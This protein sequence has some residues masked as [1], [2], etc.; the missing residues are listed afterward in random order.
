MTIVQRHVIEVLRWASKKSGMDLLYG[1]GKR[2]LDVGCAFGYTSTALKNLG[3]TTYG[4]DISRWGIRRAKT[5]SNG[6]FMV[7]NAQGTIPFV[8]NSFDLVTCFDVLEHLICPEEALS[9]MLEV[10][11]NII[12]CTTPNKKVEKPIRKL[13]G[14]Y[15]KTHISA[16]S[17]TEWRKYLT[18]YKVYTIGVEAFYDCSVSF[19]N[20]LFFKSFNIPTYGLTIRL[21][22]KK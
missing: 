12:V 3:Y 13:T 16:K 8:A 22:I 5:Q 4:L 14:D 15:D 6:E 19:R 1:K 18:K 9:S 21:V 10:A 7:C 2:A 20:K 11:K 17:I